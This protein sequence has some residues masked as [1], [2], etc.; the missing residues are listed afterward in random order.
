MSARQ[1]FLF[2]LFALPL[3]GQSQGPT[4]TTPS[5]QGQVTNGVPKYPW[6]LGTTATIFWIGEAPSGRNRT[7]NHKSSW[8]TNWQRNYGG[9]DNP[10]PAARNG[11][12]PKAFTPRLNPFYIALPYN[13][14]INHRQHKPEAS[15]VIPWFARYNPAPGQTV[16][17]GRWVEIVRNGKTCF[18][19]WEDC[20]P[21]NTT[22]W[23]FVFKNKAPKN[24]ENKGAGI[25]ISPAVRDYFGLKSG[26]KV[27][28]RFVEFADVKRGPWSLYG[29]NNPFVNP[30]ARR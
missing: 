13:D 8:D 24:T 2:L 1:L 23:E 19:Q 22:D 6:H 11:Y 10:D 21:F 27:H 20:G 17:R 9:Y 14:V 12:I 26:Q 5:R 18:A 25:D 4:V 16:C 28:W 7:P 29:T 3:A 30:R 15:K